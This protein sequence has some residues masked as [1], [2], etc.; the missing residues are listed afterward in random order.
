MCMNEG[1][2]Q[3]WVTIACAMAF[4]AGTVGTLREAAAQEDV[5]RDRVVELEKRVQDLRAAEKELRDAKKELEKEV[6]LR[7]DFN[8]R[9]EDS[10][11]KG[12]GQQGGNVTISMTDNQNGTEYTLQVQNGTTTAK[13]DGRALNKDEYRT[14]DGRV[15]FLDKDGNVE[16]TMQLPHAG[17]QWG[18]GNVFRFAPRAQRSMPGLLLDGDNVARAEAP[19]PVMLGITMSDDDSGAMID[20]VRDDLPADK[21][22]MK[23]GD[24]IVEIDGK[25]VEGQSDVRSIL[26]KHKDGDTVDVIV[27]RDG[28]KKTLRVELA[29]WDAEKLGQGGAQA[30]TVPGVPAAPDAPDVVDPFNGDMSTWWRNFAGGLGGDSKEALTSAREALEAALEQVDGAKD[31]LEEL[32]KAAKDGLE[33]A[34]ASL[35]EAEE[36]AGTRHGVRLIAP[37]QEG[38]AQTLVLPE[39]REFNRARERNDD[40]RKQFE[41]MREQMKEL[42]KQM[43]EANKKKDDR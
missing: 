38:G 6:E 4:L 11:V 35:K 2:G 15:E 33:A 34:I 21:A 43:E 40:L 25:S 24:V 1:T 12:R 39:V 42:Q 41:E 10:L 3:R 27:L 18:G 37:N 36:K 32:R 9:L 28:E 14:V 30:W 17:G 22:G 13:K 29:A 23:A 20:S 19:P 16:H 7:G 31:N 8:R 5:K 26:K